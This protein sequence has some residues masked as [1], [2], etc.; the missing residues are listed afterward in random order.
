M[1]MRNFLFLLM[2]LALVVGPAGCIFSPDDDSGDGGGGGGDV[3]QYPSDP[4]KLMQNFEEIYNGM[5]I[6]P[7]KEMLHEDYRTVLLPSTLQEW[8]EGGNPL[9]EDVFYR[10]DEIRIH[11]NMF[12]GNTGLDAAGT[13][14]PPI[15][16]IQVDYLVKSG[17]WE[18][19]SDTDPNFAGQ[20]GYWA[21]YNVL[22]YFNN[23]DQHRFEV[24]QDVEFY[25]VPTDDAG[26]TKWLLLGQR[27]LE[28][29]TP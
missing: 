3:L 29:S 19:I 7:F 17:A 10:D 20:G 14:V 26:R 5:L 12:S 2:A 15:E 23:P 1:K 18:Q 8:E 28:P 9:A 16:S 6:D 11:E 13:T 22:I 27:G 4:D 21:L 25:V 24:R